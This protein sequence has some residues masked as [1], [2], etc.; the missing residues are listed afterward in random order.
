MND[1]K[2]Q[3]ISEM[4]TGIVQENGITSIDYII[5]GLLEHYNAKL[6]L[7][8]LQ[9]QMKM[10]NPKAHSFIEVGLS[11]YITTYKR[12]IK[13]RIAIDQIANNIGRSPDTVKR[14]I[15]SFR[16]YVKKELK[17]IEHKEASTKD[18]SSCITDIVKYVISNMEG[19][20]NNGREY[21]ARDYQEWVD[22]FFRVKKEEKESELPF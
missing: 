12:G 10:E 6:I 4:I 19:Y 21:S 20:E 14:H 8:K 9:I 7:R 22:N 1:E 16:A 18:I 3:Y 15:D 5:A 13:Q 11:V 17:E 2:K